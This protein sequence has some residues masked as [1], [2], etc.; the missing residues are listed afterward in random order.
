MSKELS[1]KGILLEKLNRLL[2]PN[3]DTKFIWGLFSTGV[4]LIGYQRL[5]KLA[6][7]LEILSGNTYVK[8]S[9]TSGADAVFIAIGAVMV[10]ASIFLFFWRVLS[11][12]PKRK[13]T[14]K[15]L[16]K[17]AKVIRPLMDENRRIFTAFGPNSE[18]GNTGE[19]RHD[20]EVWEGLKKSKIAPNN[21]E[22]LGILNS[23]N[24]FSESEKPIVDKMKSHIEAFKEHCE[25][26]MFDYS[27]NQF[28]LSFADL[29][30]EYSKS[31]R[32]N[33]SKY[34][35]W[36]KLKLS[37]Y[38]DVVDSVHVYGSSLYGEESED[39]DVVIKNSFENINDVREF[40]EFIRSLK[41]DF[42][43]EFSLALHLKVFSNIESESY[44]KFMGK[45]H[46]TE[47]VI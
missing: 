5:V 23:V 21:D 24:N 17:A 2:N 18:S 37:G 25:N 33:V 6:S 30:F 35:E 16:A 11:Q 43:S 31:K 36:L 32:N 10:L 27:Q 45:I 1:I 47:R 44:K 3:F 34:S 41:S 20:Y 8:L 13:K 9:L 38:S 4:F 14:Y 12:S 46:R 40:S 22:I 29:I 42:Y 39:V 19:L 28:P 26:P 15:S 7:S